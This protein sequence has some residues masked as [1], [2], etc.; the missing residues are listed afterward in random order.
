MAT[1]QQTIIWCLSSQVWI[2][3]K[4]VY[5]PN[6]EPVWS[7]APTFPSW[8]PDAPYQTEVCLRSHFGPCLAS[9]KMRFYTFY[10][11]C[12]VKKQNSRPTTEWLM[13]SPVSPHQRELPFWIPPETESSASQPGP[14]WSGQ[15]GVRPSRPLPAPEEKELV[16]THP[17]FDP[18]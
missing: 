3:Q 5:G 12:C 13:L 11:F 7:C 6:S 14:A 4:P 16:I 8:R 18:G 17:L 10:S 15:G 1:S 2:F 9:F